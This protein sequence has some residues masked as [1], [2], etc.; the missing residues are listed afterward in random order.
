MKK[1][2]MLKTIQLVVYVI[3]AIV[4]VAKLVLDKEVYHTVGT[5]PTAHLLFI[6]LWA[7]FALTFLFIFLD[8]TLSAS[9]KKDFREL[10]FAVHSDPLSGMSN[11]NSCDAI[12]DKYADRQVPDNIGC[13]MFELSNIRETNQLFG[14]SA[15]NQEI[16]EFANILVSSSAGLCFVGRN[17]GNK[18]LAIFENGT[19]ESITKF[20]ALV[21]GHVIEHNKLHHQ[22]AIAYRIGKAF[23]EGP[24]IT[25]INQLVA[26]ADRRM[27]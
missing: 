24:E 7:L 16:R 26:L 11:R 17:G 27:R 4:G 13:I 21:E 25:R 8:F 9:M 18:F 14:H 3:L 6:F 23:H 19:E 10:D 5:N 1:I 20:T 22:S 2:N 12:I 15:G